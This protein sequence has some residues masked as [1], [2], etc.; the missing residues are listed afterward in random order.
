M[1]AP[2]IYTDA[3]A[4]NKAYVY[5]EGDYKG[6]EYDSKVVAGSDK[7]FVYG[8]FQAKNREF[9]DSLKT[10]QGRDELTLPRLPE[11]HGSGRKDSGAGI[12]A[13]RVAPPSGE[14]RRHGMG[15]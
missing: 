2:G 6:V 1:H 7:N 8:G 5:A 15:T 13:R 14:A 11:D 4:E 3:E 12:V 10:G 9:I